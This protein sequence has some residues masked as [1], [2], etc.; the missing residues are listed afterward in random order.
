MTGRNSRRAER[1]F[2]QGDVGSAGE[3]ECL[4]TGRLKTKIRSASRAH[5]AVAAP[6]ARRPNNKCSPSPSH[7]SVLHPSA[8][9]LL[10]LF[11]SLSSSPSSA[12]PSPSSLSPVAPSA[13]RLLRPP[14]LL[15]LAECKCS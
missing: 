2:T 1:I 10:S 12:L 3:P 6:S 8:S 9:L 11:I 13:P 14:R 7:S 4:L 5:R 15:T